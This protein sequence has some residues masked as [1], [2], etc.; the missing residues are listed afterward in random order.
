MVI[1]VIKDCLCEH[2]VHEIMNYPRPGLVE[3]KF[4]SGETFED[5]KEWSNFYGSY[6][7]VKVGSI[8][9]DISKSNAK[10]IQR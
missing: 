5:V 4:K 9:H 8:Y 7:R 6:Y 10:I 3:K 1:E 2:Y